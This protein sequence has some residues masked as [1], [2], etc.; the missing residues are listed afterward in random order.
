MSSSENNK[1][2]RPNLTGSVNKDELLKKM[3]NRD[4]QRPELV[5]TSQLVTTDTDMMWGYLANKKKLQPLDSAAQSEAPK[6]NEEKGK[7]K[8][9][10]K[11]YGSL[12]NSESDNKNLNGVLEGIGNLDDS[13]DSIINLKINDKKDETNNDTKDNNSQETKNETQ[14][15]EDKRGTEM[16]LNRVMPTLDSDDSDMDVFE[17]PFI[18]NGN[19]NNNF[20]NAFAN[21]GPTNAGSTNFNNFKYNTYDPRR[22]FMKP[23]EEPLPSDHEYVEKV[24]LLARI[25]EIEDQVKF[26]KKFT[27]KDDYY[28]MRFEYDLKKSIKDRKNGIGLAKGFLMNAVST[29]EFLNDQ[30]DPFDVKLKGWSENMNCNLESYND[31]FGELYDKYRDKGGKMAPELKLL[32][33][34]SSSAVQFHLSKTLFS[35][36]GLENVL[37]NNPSLLSKLMSGGMNGGGNSPSQEQM[38]AILKQEAQKQAQ[39]QI[40]QMNTKMQEEYNKR[41]TQQQQMYEQQMNMMKQQMNQMSQMMQNIHGASVKKQENEES[42]EQINLALQQRQEVEL[43]QKQMMMQQEQL[44]R[45]QEQ[46]KQ[47]QIRQQEQIK[48]QQELMKQKEQLR[49]QQE[50]KQQEQK[51]QEQQKEFSEV[52]DDFEGPKYSAEILNM[53]KMQQRLK[54]REKDKESKSSKSSLSNSDRVTSEVTIDFPESVV[55]GRSKRRKKKKNTEV[56]IDISK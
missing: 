24:R 46:M 53:I 34:V 27:M 19:V 50:Q 1:N 56:K 33:M 35:G 7:E 31:V 22:R 16:S 12:S 47:E 5:T 52:K 51:Q 23:G 13:D 42:S 18:Q 39:Q 54:N 17:K 48:N 10:D 8:E 9:N 38:Q 43:M 26:S 45:Q 14:D 3:D 6:K 36:P 4:K 21:A 2:S 25:E 40:Q 44:R 20:T 28:E 41:I 15:N 49:L 30:Y 37:G 55:L 11:K 29:I 32:L